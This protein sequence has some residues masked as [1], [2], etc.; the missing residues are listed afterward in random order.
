MTVAALHAAFR[1][2]FRVWP[3]VPRCWVAFSGGL[4]STVLLDLMRA[5]QADLPPFQAIHVDH[6]LHPDST[7]WAE[8]CR[9]WCARL[10][11]QCTVVSIPCTVPP[12]ASLEA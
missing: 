2:A 12:G 7:R 10:E 3:P 5:D 11:I 6:G 8:H 1:A 9:A 4:D